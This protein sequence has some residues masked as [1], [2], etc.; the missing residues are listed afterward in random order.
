MIPI[1]IM[2]IIMLIM[3]MIFTMIMLTMIMSAAQHE[4]LLDWKAC[5][6]AC[7]WEEKLYQQTW[8]RSF[9]LHAK[10]HLRTNRRQFERFHCDGTHDAHCVLPRK[11]ARS[12]QK[13]LL[14][15]SSTRIRISIK[16]TCTTS[17]NISDEKRCSALRQQS[18]FSQNRTETTA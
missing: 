18:G 12:K 8:L 6:R 13:R 17:I 7:K 5:K 10:L 15:W 3:V 9:A 14:Y 2:T 1:M 4:K 11:L 16:N